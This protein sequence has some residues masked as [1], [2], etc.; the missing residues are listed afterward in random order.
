MKIWITRHGQ[1]DLNK[2]QLMCGL[3]DI[4]LNET[5]IEQAK[6]ARSKI[7]DIEFDAVYASPL[8]RAIKTG[9][10]I[11]NVPESQVIIDPR[12]IEV[13]FGDYE[14]RKYSMLG[15]RMSAYWALPEIIPN[16][17]SVE[18]ISSMIERS[19]SFLKEIEQKD[20]KN[21]L[22]ACHGGIIRALKGYMEDK[23][24]G[25]SWRPKPH[26]CEIY[27]YESKNGQHSFIEK[28]LND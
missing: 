26:N 2:Q 11:G 24:T 12:I 7:D 21:V 19:Q 3:T 8:Q 15:I 25:I 6:R 20:Y 18:P 16:P 13:N 28:I 27:V 22:I 14:K 17:K 1:T 23:K 5:G 4:P 10:I 9:S